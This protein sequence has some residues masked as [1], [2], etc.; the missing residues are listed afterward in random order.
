MQLKPITAIIVLTLVVASLSVAGCTILPAPKTDNQASNVSTT[1]LV[2]TAYPTAGKS[3]LLR[4]IVADENKSIGSSLDG[5]KVTWINNSTVKIEGTKT[6]NNF[7]LV[8]TF[9]YTF[10]HFPTANAASAYFDSNRPQYTETL[11]ANHSSLYSRVT[12]QNAT[13]INSVWRLGTLRTDEVTYTLEQFDALII[14]T[15]SQHHIE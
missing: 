7:S 14:E 12:G 3:E 10:T 5:Y 8:Q 13:V 11:L 9:N 15:S 1:T 2:S 6:V 4:A